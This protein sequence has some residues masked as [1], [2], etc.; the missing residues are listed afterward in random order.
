VN[1]L[2][3]VRFASLLMGVWFLSTAAA[4]NFAGVL[5]G[6]YPEEGKAKSFVGFQIADMFDF[7][8]LFVVL[9]GAASLILFILSKYLVKLMHGVR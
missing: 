1:K 4:N 6:F 3:P 9:S 5:S 7:F 8:M 2:R